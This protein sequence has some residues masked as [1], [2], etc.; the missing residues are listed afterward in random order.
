MSGTSGNQGKYRRQKRKKNPLPQSAHVHPPA[1]AAIQSIAI[2]VKISQLPDGFVLS[3]WDYN[4][5]LTTFQP[6]IRR[7]R[8]TG[9]GELTLMRWG[10]IPW[11]ADSPDQVKDLSPINTRAPRLLQ[12]PS[13]A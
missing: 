10:L 2:T 11:F 9:G 13:G 4:V 3:P 7:N 8:D 5:A 6:V 12:K 1:R